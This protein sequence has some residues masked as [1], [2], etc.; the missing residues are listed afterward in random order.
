VGVAVKR[1]ALAAGALLA[2]VAAFL[3]GR[4]SRLAETKTET[5]TVYAAH[6]KDSGS[7]SIDSGQKA[8][9]RVVTVTKR[10]PGGTVYVTETRDSLLDSDLELD[11][12][13]HRESETKAET[14]TTTTTRS[15][16]SWRLDAQAGWSRL[17]PAPD[18]Y[19]IGISRRIAGTLWV[20]GWART[21]KTAGLGVG[22]EW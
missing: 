3:G 1:I 16:P 15:Q 8:R 22:L 5:V 12:G 17:S 21:D 20:G 14:K 9:E 2:L 19:G 6:S 7:L 18:I 4:F 10:E 13:W 11:L